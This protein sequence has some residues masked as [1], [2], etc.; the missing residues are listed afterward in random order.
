MGLPTYLWAILS[1]ESTYM[2]KM[3]SRTCYSH[4]Q[5]KQLSR[6][7]GNQTWLNDHKLQCL[8]SLCQSSR[9]PGQKVRTPLWKKGRSFWPSYRH[10]STTTV[11]TPTQ[12][13]SPQYFSFLLQKTPGQYPYLQDNVSNFGSFSCRAEKL[14]A[15]PAKHI[16]DKMVHHITDAN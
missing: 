5:S 16:G 12:N 7:A 8:Y 10:I 11:G 6:A 1:Q 2:E 15:S 14:S 13:L 4:W 3:K 9:K